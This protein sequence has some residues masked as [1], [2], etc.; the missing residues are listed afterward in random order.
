GSESPEQSNLSPIALLS[1][2][3][4]TRNLDAEL[5]RLA[6]SGDA[7][8]MAAVI[9]L[10]ARCAQFWSSRGDRYHPKHELAKLP[11]AS[12]ERATRESALQSLT[13]YCDRPYAPGEVAERVGQFS[14][15]LEELASKGDLVAMAATGFK[16]QGE[17]EVLSAMLEADKPWVVEQAMHAFASGKGQLSRQLDEEVFPFSLRAMPNQLELGKIKS[18]AARW[19]ACELGAACGPNQFEELNQCVLWGNCGL[20]L[21]VQA[22][23]RNRE[24]SGYQFELMQRYLAALDAKFKGGH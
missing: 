23:I 10:S 12:S 16:G 3:S 22:Y 13:Q 6:N 14:G 17:V 4:S 19:R 20:G 8:A 18:M 15:R 24:L 1:S 7:E 11:A 2:A 5:M 9:N 21:G